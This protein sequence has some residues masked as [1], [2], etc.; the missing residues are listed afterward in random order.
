LLLKDRLKS[1]FETAVAAL[2]LVGMG[3]MVWWFFGGLYMLQHLKVPNYFNHGP[4]D[5]VDTR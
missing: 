2:C 5:P 4:Q 3:A 1:Y